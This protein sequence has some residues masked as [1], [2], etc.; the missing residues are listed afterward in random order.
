MRHFEYRTTVIHHCFDLFA[1]H[2]RL[3]NLCPDG[4][5]RRFLGEGGDY[6]TMAIHCTSQQRISVSKYSAPSLSEGRSHDAHSELRGMDDILSHWPLISIY[7]R[8]SRGFHIGT[9][10]NCPVHCE[11]ADN[12][13]RALSS[14]TAAGCRTDCLN[15]ILPHCL[16][17]SDSHYH[18]PTIRQRCRLC[19][20]SASSHHRLNA[21]PKLVS[22]K[23]GRQ[24]QVSIAGRA[25]KSECCLL[26]IY[27]SARVHCN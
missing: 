16:N 5:I 8:P 13:C 15:H 21:W 25:T 17:F 4:R 20:G 14:K 7:L 9:W 12:A 23:A 24:V 26:S 18:E 3:R 1:T 27:Y 10:Y 2:R 6:L 19:C 22:A 11:Y